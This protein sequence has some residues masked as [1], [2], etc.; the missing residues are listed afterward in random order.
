MNRRHANVARRE[1][2]GGPAGEAGRERDRAAVQCREISSVLH[3]RRD[4]FVRS[5]VR[6]G[7]SE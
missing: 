3:P 2:G 5:N 4:S 1:R 6:A 7:V